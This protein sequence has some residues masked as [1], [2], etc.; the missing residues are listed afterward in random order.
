MPSDPHQ[1]GRP[2]MPVKYWSRAGLMLTDWCNAACACCYASCGPAGRTW[3]SVA[4]AVGIWRDLLEASPHGC[5]VHLTGGEVFGRFDYLLELCR[6]AQSEGL[7]PLEA[8]ETNGYW[9]ED[10]ADVR[11]R[12]EALDAAGM[13]RLTVSTDPYHQRHVPIERVRLLVRI[14]EQILGPN[15]VRVRFRDWLADG[16][17]LI[18]MP[19]HQVEEAFTRYATGG[20]ERLTGRAAEGLDGE[21]PL[22]TAAEFD[23]KP[24]RER[25]L[26][27]RHVHSAPTGEIWPATCVGIVVGNALDRPA[28][29]I[30]ADLNAEFDRLAVVGELSRRGPVGLLEAARDHGF[31]PRPE[32]YAGKC[33]LCFHLRRHLRRSGAYA[34]ALGPADVYAGAAVEN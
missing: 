22:K 34:A 5:R 12:L 7:G 31:V 27:G 17:D 15:R 3:M 24:C 30:W 8:I 4:A 1:T 9:A 13:G 33:Q 25:I 2:P 6:A 29:D 18:D 23:D 20:R 14:A 10:P 16:F 26:R 11:Q 28:R 21:M 19:Q 32:G